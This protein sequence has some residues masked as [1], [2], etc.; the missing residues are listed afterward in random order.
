[1]EAIPANKSNDKKTTNSTYSLN[2]ALLEEKV[3][4]LVTMVKSLKKEN[5]DLMNENKSL[6]DQLKALEGSLV[7]ETKD[8]EELSQEKIMTKMAVDDLLKSIDELIDQK[9]K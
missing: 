3:V 6:Q 5:A 2:L 7:S 9:E 8:L 1:M 4:S